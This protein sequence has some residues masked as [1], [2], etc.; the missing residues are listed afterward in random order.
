MCMEDI[1]L[2]RES[3]TNV[4]R[5]PSPSGTLVAPANVNRIRLVFCKAGAGTVNITPR[6]L[7]ATPTS[8]DGIQLTD[9]SP[10]AIVRIEDYGDCVTDDWFAVN[11][12]NGEDVTVFDTYLQKR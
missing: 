4:K 11:D 12:G 1:R 10:I 6:R 3:A 5:I 9:G 2:G 7:S 8:A